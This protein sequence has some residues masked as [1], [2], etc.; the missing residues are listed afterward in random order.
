MGELKH[1]GV[2]GMKWGVRRDDRGSTKAVTKGK[3]IVKSNSKVKVKSLPNEK[4]LGRRIAESK[5]FVK[6]VNALKVTDDVTST[7]GLAAR[8]AAMAVQE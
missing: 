4:S 3:K 6:T 7:A 1:Y 2:L 5:A 8:L